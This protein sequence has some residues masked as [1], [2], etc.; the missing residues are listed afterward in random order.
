MACFGPESS[1]LT[2]NR[3]ESEDNKILF[4]HMRDRL[5]QTAEAFAAKEFAL[6]SVMKERENYRKA[7]KEI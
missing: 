5:K 4:G 6:F 2:N 1:K 3:S 7:I